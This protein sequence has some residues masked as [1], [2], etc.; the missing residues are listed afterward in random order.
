MNSL[1]VL[2]RFPQQICV[3]KREFF[4]SL[5]SF[6]LVE[7]AMVTV[8]IWVLHL[9]FVGNGAVVYCWKFCDSGALI[10]FLSNQD[11]TWC[12]RVLCLL[13]HL[14]FGA[15]LLREDTRSIWE[16]IFSFS[17]S[18]QAVNLFLLLPL[19]CLFSTFLL[20]FGNLAEEVVKM[21]RMWTSTVIFPAKQS[22]LSQN[23]QQS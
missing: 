1:V 4:E 18:D 14:W 9:I 3:W 11:D 2:I 21:H 6:I 7:S 8:Y 22:P 19:F 12:K 17:L 23:W 16:N 15:G 5:L 13:Q 10:N 20:I